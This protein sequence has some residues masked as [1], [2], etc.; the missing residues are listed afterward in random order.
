MSLKN[1]L[2][3]HWRLRLTTA[4]VHGNVSGYRGSACSVLNIIPTS[5]GKTIESSL[6]IHALHFVLSKLPVTAVFQ[7][8]VLHMT[9]SAATFEY[10]FLESNMDFKKKNFEQNR[11]IFVQIHSVKNLGQTYYQSKCLRV[12][13]TSLKRVI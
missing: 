3:S 12:K 10:C 2:C 5:S 4:H 9:K 7:K 13:E 11:F 1:P 6:Q 8:V